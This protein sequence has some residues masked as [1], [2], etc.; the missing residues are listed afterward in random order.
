MFFSSLDRFDLVGVGSTDS[1]ADHGQT[2]PDIASENLNNGNGRHGDQCCE[3]EVFAQRLSATAG[4][5]V[6]ELHGFPFVCLR[7]RVANNLANAGSMWGATD[8]MIEMEPYKRRLHL[9]RSEVLLIF[10]LVVLMSSLM[11]TLGV[12]VGSGLNGTGLELKGFGTASKVSEH[13]AAVASQAGHEETEAH[14]ESAEQGERHPASVA[15]KEKET[16][17]SDL[18]KAFRDSKQRALV[19]M[20]LRDTP[21]KIPK[22]VADA[23]AHFE[24]TKEWDRKPAALE[25]EDKDKDKEVVQKPVEKVLNQSN[26]TEL[27]KLFERRPSSIDRFSPTPGAYTVQVASYASQDEST[28]KITEL[29]KSGFNDAYVQAIRLKNGESWFR[30]AV[31]SFPSPAWAKKAGEKLVKRKL[32]SDFVIRQVN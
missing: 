21:N 12:V 27:K 8:T 32:A 2:R 15:E 13:G 16:P 25:D 1:V 22:S 14:E 31:G 19:D 6:F 9:D 11:F 20:T 7:G 29:R 18:R 5:D 4:L 26:T 17:G 23:E 24:A 10:G 28:A 3:N 30:V